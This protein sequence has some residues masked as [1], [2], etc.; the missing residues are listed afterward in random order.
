MASCKDCSFYSETIDEL[1][2]NF[3]DVGDVHNH[4]CPMYQ[5][6]IPAGVFNG[7]KSCEFYEDKQ[8]S[9]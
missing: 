8:Q 9:E 1:N 7:A 3:N 2:R 5:D 4:Y 6:A